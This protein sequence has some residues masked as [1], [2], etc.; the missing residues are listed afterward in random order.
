MLHKLTAWMLALLI[1][2]PICWCGWMHGDQKVA[3][4]EKP[5]CCPHKKESTEQK[6]APK[7]PSDCPCSQ[8]PK[9]RELA[10]SKVM[11]PAVPVTDDTLA[12]WNPLLLE[13]AHRDAAPVS[14]EWVLNHGPPLPGE[15]LF[16]RHCALLI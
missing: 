12:T 4:N 2:S 5:S 9:V 14:F 7:D 1:A 16:L 13:L 6:Q 11:I 3:V 8:L 15:P 10:V